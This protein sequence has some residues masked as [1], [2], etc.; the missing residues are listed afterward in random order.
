MFEDDGM[1]IFC[2]II[3]LAVLFF[4]LFISSEIK[5]PDEIKDTNCIYYEKQIYCLQESEEK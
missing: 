3:F 2:V 4:C 5:L 1:T